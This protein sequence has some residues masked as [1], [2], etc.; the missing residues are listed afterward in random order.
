MRFEVLH[1]KMLTVVVVG[2]NGSNRK[3]ISTLTWP[4]NCFCHYKITLT[5]CK[6]AGY[7]GYEIVVKWHQL[8][9]THKTVVFAS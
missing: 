6:E 4:K 5:R 3:K 9:D 8:F 1:F 7:G 2:S